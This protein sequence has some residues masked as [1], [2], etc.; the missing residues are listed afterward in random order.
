MLYDCQSYA[1]RMLK[2]SFIRSKATLFIVLPI[3]TCI[4][5]IDKHF[6]PLFV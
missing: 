1:L 5:A 2:R 4:T 3:I 6:Y